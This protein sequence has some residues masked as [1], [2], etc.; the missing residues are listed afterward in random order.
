M[1]YVK[2][3]HFVSGY[4]SRQIKSCHVMRY[5][6]FKVFHFVA[7]RV[8]CRIKL[9][10][11]MHYV[12]LRHFVSGHVSRRIKSYHVFKSSRSYHV[13]TF[14]SCTT[15][16]DVILSPVM[17]HVE[18]SHAMSCA[19]SKYIISSQVI[20]HAVLCTICHVVYENTSRNGSRS[21]AICY[22]PCHPTSR[23][24]SRDDNLFAHFYRECLNGSTYR[25]KTRLSL[26]CGLHAC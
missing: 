3:R 9:C 23:S 11:V 18:L 16:E 22:A 6:K 10:H 21:V 15:S 24:L 13:F 2:V 4:V 25:F 14:M 17:C 20:C 12:K 8:T 7:G 1:H 5:V 26:R 19:T